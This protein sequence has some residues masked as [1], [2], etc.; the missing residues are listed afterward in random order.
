MSGYTPGPWKHGCNYV[1]T[2]N[3]CLKVL[4]QTYS[5]CDTS[6]EEALENAR[7]M[8]AAPDLLQEIKRIL[9]VLE[10]LYEDGKAWYKFSFGSGVATLNGIKRV[11]AKAEGR[12]V[13][14]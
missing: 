12:E 13:T 9:P 1:R 6:R 3:G 8:A 7:M 5:G 2:D 14:K 4:A 11:I 10:S